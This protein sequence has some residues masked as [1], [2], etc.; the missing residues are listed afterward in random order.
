MKLIFISIGVFILAVACTSKNSS[1]SSDL[2]DPGVHEV[3]VEE[4][5]QV[6]G[7]TYLRVK[8]NN[9]EQWLAVTTLEAKQGETYYYRDGFQMTNF[10]SKELNK[11]FDAITF[12]E[13]ISS[14][15]PTSTKDKQTVSPGSSK[16]NL[17]KIIVNITPADGGI[18]ISEL[19]RNKENY[20]GK[21]L[22]IRGQVAKFTPDIMGKNWIHLQDGSEFNGSFDLAITSD[23]SVNVGDTVTF[24]GEITLNKDLGYGYFFD[25]LMENASTK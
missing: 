3:K 20:A 8:E 4:V 10:N 11:T 7:Y 18:S 6:P 2:S 22:T 16:S 21:R 1:K 15:P 13:T 23:K 17:K 24:Q 19:Y 14:E 9:V 25:V 12:I 5:I